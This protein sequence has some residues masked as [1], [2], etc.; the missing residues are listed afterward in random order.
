MSMDASTALGPRG[1]KRN[2]SCDDLLEALELALEEPVQ[3]L[4]LP[5]PEAE[6]QVSP[7]VD[8]VI[9]Y[10]EMMRRALVDWGD[11]IIDTLCAK[12]GDDLPRVK[13]H[14]EAVRIEL[15]DPLRATLS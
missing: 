8:H 11:E 6:R 7:A 12:F 5:P 1:S 10:H 15:V 9:K 2:S 4:P 14:I 13:S 3:E